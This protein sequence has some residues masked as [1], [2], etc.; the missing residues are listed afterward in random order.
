M[1]EITTNCSKFFDVL[2]NLCFITLHTILFPSGIDYIF[3]LN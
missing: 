3:F 2:T 1:L